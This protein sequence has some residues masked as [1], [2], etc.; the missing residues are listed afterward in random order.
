[1]PNGSVLCI[2]IADDAGEPM[3]MV[4]EVMAITGAGLLGDRYEKTQGS[5]NREHPGS[6]QVSLIDGII[7]GSGF[8][9]PETRRNIATVNVDLM[10]LIG[11]EF[12][13]GDAV[14]RGVA[15]CDPCDRP[16]KLAGKDINFKKA[17]RERG[18]IIA[19]VLTDGIIKQCSLIVPLAKN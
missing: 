3:R 19:E 6:R 4:D 1:M 7:E 8:T 10:S 2:Y 14:M 15:P 17:F 9:Y 12:R 18:G 11:K 5:F 13:I 16:S